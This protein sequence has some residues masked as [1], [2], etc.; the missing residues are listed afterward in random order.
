MEIRHFSE[1]L[2]KV[3]QVGGALLPREQT[4]GSEDLHNCSMFSSVSFMEYEGP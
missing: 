3:R 4:F 1:D 2:K